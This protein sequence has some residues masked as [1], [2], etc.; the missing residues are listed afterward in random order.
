MKFV[1]YENFWWMY[2]E[3]TPK[4]CA[5]LI[6]IYGGINT[7]NDITNLKIVEAKS[8]DELDWYGT[9]VYSDKYKYGWLDRNGKFYGCSYESH[10]LQ[11][12][13]VHHSSR[14]ELEKMGWIHISKDMAEDTGKFVAHF[15]GDY[16]NGIMPT[17]AQ[18]FYLSKHKDIDCE[19]V[20]FKYMNG[21]REKAKQYEK[22]LLKNK[23][24]KKQDKEN[25]M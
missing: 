24:S 16:E 20:M 3:K 2:D 1:L 15:F 18:M 21:N 4:K 14:R 7:K 6:N 22:E 17:D 12:K 9:D 8:F 10:D 19:Y 11:A 13:F 25:L 23:N 5:T